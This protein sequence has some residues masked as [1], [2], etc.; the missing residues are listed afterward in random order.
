MLPV[1]T[2]S[3]CAEASAGAGA[4]CGSR[5][6]DLAG[7]FPLEICCATAG[8]AH[9]TVPNSAVVEPSAHRV[10]KFISLSLT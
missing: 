7:V 8:A 5:G 10:R 2:I 4:A 1:T 6:T 9:A 3:G